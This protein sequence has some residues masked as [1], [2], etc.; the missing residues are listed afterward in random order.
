MANPILEAFQWGAGGAKLTPEQI[1]RQREIAASL[2]KGDPAFHNAGW[3]GAIGRGLEGAYSGWTEGRADRAEKA[4]IEAQNALRAGIDFSNLFGGGSTAAG[5]PDLG[6]SPAASTAMATAPAPDIAS[7]RVAQAHGDSGGSFLPQSFLGALDRTEGA[8]NYDTLFGHAQRSGPFAGTSVS[9]MPISEVLAFA[10]PSGAYGQHV[11]GQVGRVATPM[12]RHQIVGTTLRNAVGELGIDPSTPFNAQTQDQIAA[13][14]AKRRIAGAST[15]DGKISGLRSEWEGFR[16]VPRAEMEQIVRDLESMPANAVAANEAMASGELAN[17]SL[18]PDAIQQWAAQNYAPEQAAGVTVAETPEE[19]LAAE[20]AMASEMAPPLPDPTMVQDM[21]V[22]D[23]ATGPQGMGS[24]T[25]GETRRGPD[26]RLYQYAQT[27]GMAGATG[28]WGWIPVADGGGG[29][30]DVARALTGAT[31]NPDLPMAGNTSGFLPIAQSLAA[32]PQGAG[33]SQMQRV[34]ELASSPRATDMDRQIAGALIKQQMEQADPYRQAQLEK[35]RLET[36]ALR[37]PAAPKPIEVGG[38]LLDPITFQPIFDSRQ[39]DGPASVQEYQFY[40][41]QMAGLGQQPLPY[42]QWDIAR[43]QSAATQVNVGS[44]GQR[45]GTIPA[46]MAAVPDPNNPSGFR[47]EAIPGG[48]A[49]ID[50]AAA[51]GQRDAQ[52][53]SDAQKAETTLDATRSVLDILD[54]ADTPATGTL[55]RPFAAFSGTP[56]GRVRS[57]VGT[58]QSGVALGAMQRLKEASATGATGFGALSAPELNLLIND[59]GALDPDNTEPDIFRKTI[60]RIQDRSRR[61]AEDIVKNVSPERIQELGLQGFIDGFSGG[62]SGGA[63][64]KPVSEMTDEELEALANG[65]G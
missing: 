63:T 58:L 51:A 59:I 10:S 3:L 64:N 25:T 29:F 46:G 49:A 15:M 20:A 5:S 23:V 11:K 52:T 47:L 24:G 65:N 32:Q 38:V 18:T 44:E 42:D 45:M 4:G 30:A 35:L 54:K 41:N 14:L 43:R 21:P 60:E 55:S 62:Q 34:M 12:G 61:V 7:A 28:D 2:M 36:E 26:G 22:A 39:N 48:P 53:V 57:Y 8:G 19:I 6:G 1:A 56:A 13:H 50:E 33:M 9:Q 27:S 37:N 40:A 16:S 31:V 17:P